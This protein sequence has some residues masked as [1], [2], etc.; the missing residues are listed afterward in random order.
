MTS[1]F[2]IGSTNWGY[3]TENSKDIGD[4]KS[5]T[6]G[7]K[8]LLT[9]WLNV[10]DDSGVRTN[11]TESAEKW[12]KTE[13]W[14]LGN[15]TSTY[16]YSSP[17]ALLGTT[18]TE[19]YT[20]GIGFYYETGRNLYGNGV[21]RNATLKCNGETD[22]SKIG[23][24]TADEV[25]FAGGKAESANFNYYLYKGHYWWT[26]SR[27]HFYGTRDHAFYVSNYGALFGYDSV[28]FSDFRVR[29]A[30]SLNT[31]AKIISGEGTKG[32]PYII[33]EG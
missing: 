3:K 32:N 5:S 10:T 30:V 29:P 9:T 19:N 22:S 25:A 23:A 7:M 2:S 24:L 14:C 8:N 17:Y 13:E 21:T 16:A 11:I 20:S 18:A 27:S 15:T 31:G 12:L 33:N 1:D 4:Y 26:L 6:S 28:D